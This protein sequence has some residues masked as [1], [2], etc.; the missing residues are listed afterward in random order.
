MV[1]TILEAFIQQCNIS[2]TRSATTINEDEGE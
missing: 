1:F 2:P